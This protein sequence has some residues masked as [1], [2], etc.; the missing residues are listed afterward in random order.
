MTDPWNAGAERRPS[1][2]ALMEL[3]ANEGRGKLKVFLGM[4]PGVGKTYAMLSVGK[5]LKAQGVDVVVGVV[6]THGRSD[7]AALLDGLEVLARRTVPYRKH[8]LMEFDVDAAIARRPGLLLVDEFAHTNAPGLVHAKRYQDVE[9]I[10]QAGIDVWTTMNIQHLDSLNDVVARITGITVHETIPDRVL[11]RADEIVVVDLPPEELIQ[12]LKDGKVYLPDNARR[13]IG[14]FFKPGNL[15]ALRELALRRTAAR[16]DEQMLAQLRQ[17]GIEGPWPTADRLLVCVAGDEFAE[18]IVRSA[19]RM[20]QAQKGEWIALHLMQSDRET[21]D[22]DI[23]K[24]SDKALRLAERLGAA[25]VRLNTTD[26][27]AGLLAYAKRNNITQIVIGRSAANRFDKWFGRSLS[28]RILA[29]AKGITVTVI[30]PDAAHEPAKHSWIPKPH[31][32]V[33][34]ALAASLFVAAA[35]SVGLVAEHFTPV[36]NLSMLFL[37]AVL[38]SAIRYGI[39]TAVLSSVL[40]FL[41]YNFFFIDPRHTLTIAQ[42]H[43]F[44]SLL[45]FLVV[46]AVT[47]GL[48]GRLHEQAVAT[49]LRAEATQSLYDFSRKLTGA[50]GLDEVLWLLAA[51]C[52]ATANGRSV[53]L[54]KRDGGLAIVGSW[55]P[56][57]ELSTSDWAAARWANEKGVQAGRYTDTLPV[58]QFQ[59]RPLISTKETLGAV[60]VALGGDPDSMPSATESALQS[61]IDQA[62]VAIERTMLVDQAARVEALAETDRLRGALL[63]SVSH[64]LK[65]P[66][67][68]IVGSASSLRQLG[69]R[70]PKAAQADLLATIE[71]E[72]ERLSS[73]VTNLLDMTKLESGPLDIRRELVDAGDAVRGAV[74][75]AAKSFP[76]RKATMKIAPSLPLVRGDAALLQQVIFNLLDNANKYSDAKS[77]TNIEVQVLAGELRIIV[78]DAG[79]G[80]PADALEKVFEKFYRVAGSDGRAA[81]TGLGLSIAAALVK[82][83]GGAIRAESPAAGNKG[84]RMT[85]ALPISDEPKSAMQTQANR[86]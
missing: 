1:T 57:D 23:V 18:T 44:L 17:Q 85:I 54:L 9:G 59:F 42:P 22:R 16:V 5:A 75:R 50:K 19:S 37:L 60:G 34:S 24:R 81:G 6:E 40:S 72:A 58:A 31:V 52:A 12:R 20:T 73:F 68:S 26:M 27:A 83:M 36:P 25:S 2:K 4:A 8:T 32:G 78:S 43:E 30:T 65:T 66:L 82:A 76:A 29:E 79:V 61:F 45:T 84:T 15:T 69:D 14:Q 53:V 28:D 71:E 47:G 21:T 13:A 41:A 63:S 49:R 10:L 56:E 86:I 62:A 67:A 33:S 39:W 64:D 35:V 48:T 7:T 3:A 80:I 74:A 46:A 70:M 51:Q 55:P 77:V 38:I 11:E